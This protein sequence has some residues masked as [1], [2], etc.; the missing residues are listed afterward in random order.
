MI[1]QKFLQTCTDKQI[2]RGVAWLKV[3]NENLPMIPNSNSELLSGWANAALT[4]QIT[5]A[6]FLMTLGLLSWLIR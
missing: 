4:F 2:D 1:D 3:A 5:A 6:Q